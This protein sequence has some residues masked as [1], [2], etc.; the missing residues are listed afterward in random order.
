MIRNLEE[1]YLNAWPALQTMHY[2][3]WVLRFAAGYT[4]RA[5]SV[6]PLYPSTTDIGTKVDFCEAIYGAL[7]QNTIFKLTP[8]TQPADLDDYLDRRGYAREA[9]T[10]V[11]A[12][13]LANLGCP[14]PEDFQADSTVSAAWIEDYCTLNS[15]PRR[16]LPAM[17]GVLHNLI[18]PACYGTLRHHGATGAL[19]LAVLQGDLVALFDIVTA[20]TLR[21][22]GLGYALILN[23]LAWARDRGATRVYLQVMLNNPPALRLYEKLGFREVYQYWYRVKPY[24]PQPS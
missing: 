10:S 13:E 4:R 8:P 19:G 2:D 17:Q 1:F 16:H 21:R 18:L 15:V 23:L 12:L 24:A 22:Q 11:Q 14:A 9:T 5:N 3:G 20:P 7:G 6:N